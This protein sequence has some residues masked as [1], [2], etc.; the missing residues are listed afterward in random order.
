MTV[1]SIV[2]RA[3][4]PLQDRLEALGVDSGSLFRARGIDP[5]LLD[6]EEARLPVAV[7]DLLWADAA[8]ATGDPDFGLHLAE[9]IEPRSYGLLTYIL[10]NS[11]TLGDAWRRLIDHFALISTATRY[12]LELDRSRHW[13]VVDLGSADRRPRQVIEFLVAVAYCFGRSRSVQDWTTTAVRFAHP[14]PLDAEEHRRVFHGASLEFGASISGFTFD[15]RVLDIELA[16]ADPRLLEI[17]ERQARLVSRSSAKEHLIDEVRAQVASALGAG[18]ELSASATAR[19][20]G[21]SPRTLR[22]R[23]AEQSESF[24]AVLDGVRRQMATSLLDLGQR[25]QAVADALGFSDARSFRRAFQRWHGVS[26]A[27]YLDARATQP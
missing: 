26:P 1:P 14:A 18:S 27:A 21:M 22:R 16:R 6:S 5:A 11:A 19:A 12:R 20:L 7:T 24:S 17:L 25:P 10:S 15:R 23:L 2:A 9:S 3:L 4:E 8:E 13:L